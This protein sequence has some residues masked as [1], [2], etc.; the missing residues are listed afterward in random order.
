MGQ[1]GPVTD[2][3][4]PA[5]K[6]CVTEH[7]DHL[8]QPG[9]HQRLP[10]A[11]EAHPLDLGGEGHDFPDQLFV[12]RHL[13]VGEPEAGLLQDAVF[14]AA[15]AVHTVEAL[16]IA[17]AG[18]LHIHTQRAVQRDYFGQL[19][20]LGIITWLDFCHGLFTPVS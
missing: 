7:P 2:D 16:E 18:G 6:P 11:G 15:G 3:I 8:R 13:H 5:G 19:L 12:K 4:N 10:Q 9:I 1:E 20:P 17:G 14:L